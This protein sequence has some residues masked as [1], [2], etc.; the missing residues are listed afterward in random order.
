MKLTKK[1]QARQ[2]NNGD[3]AIEIGEHTP[4]TKQS[5][6][7]TT[8]LGNHTTNILA[9]N[10]EGLNSPSSSTNL[11]YLTP[12][13]LM[14]PIRP[15]GFQAHDDFMINH[16]PSSN[17]SHRNVDYFQPNE[18]HTNIYIHNTESHDKNNSCCN[19]KVVCGVGCFVIQWVGVNVLSDVLSHLVQDYI[20]RD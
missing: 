12:S 17:I 18:H 10:S 2:D 1:N 14:P 13:N 6:K 3:I 16:H 5:F 8:S 20:F 9:V 15:K 7:Y 4:M 19:K 11:N